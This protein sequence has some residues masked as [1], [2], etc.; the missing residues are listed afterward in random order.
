MKLG[1]V[2]GP[3]V[4]TVKH[5]DYEGKR[6]LLVELIDPDG[7]PLGSEVIAVDLV[8]SGP[9]DRVLV[10]HEGNS[11]RFLLQSDTGPLL[12]LIVALVD[13]VEYDG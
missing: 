10:M 2:R 6:V 12:D 8:Q 9:G 1:V 5:P 13:H 4:A 3:V 11:T 7:S